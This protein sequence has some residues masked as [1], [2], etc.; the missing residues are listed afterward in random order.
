MSIPEF[1]IMKDNV[2]GLPVSYSWRGHGAAIFLEF[3]ALSKDPKKNHPVGE[4]SLM[5]DCE[6]RVEG[7]NSILCGSFSEKDMIDTRLEQLLGECV[8]GI[9]ISGCLPEIAIC[10]SSDLR[11]VSFTADAGQ[12]EWT[13]FLPDRSCLCC[14]DG[15]VVLQTAEKNE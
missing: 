3:G 10:L 1:E 2:C 13:V 12:P 7:N 14:V 8:T 15:D 4:Y 6:W 5:L 11:L 9:E